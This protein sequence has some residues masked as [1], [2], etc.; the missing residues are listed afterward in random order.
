MTFWAFCVTSWLE[1]CGCVFSPRPKLDWRFLQRFFS[2]L[3]ILFPSWS[4]P[5]VRMF[6]TLLGVT[7][8]G[9]KLLTSGL[10]IW[11]LFLSSLCV[12]S[13]YFSFLLVQLVIYQVGLIPSQ[14]YEVLSEKSYGKFKDL[15]VF[16]V[17][18]ILVNSTVSLVLS[19][20]V[21]CKLLQET[22]STNYF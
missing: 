13:M 5:S 4:N 19:T 12:F 1:L 21:F 11:W 9:N 2:I 6:M 16:A 20:V 18:L 14:F 22:A 3:K 15:V 8:S 17:L 7:L 10:G